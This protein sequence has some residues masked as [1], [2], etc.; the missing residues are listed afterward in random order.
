MPMAASGSASVKSAF[1]RARGAHVEDR[2]DRDAARGRPRASGA[3]S[4][5]RQS[6]DALAAS[7]P[8]SL[9]PWGTAPTDPIGEGGGARRGAVGTASSTAG[10]EDESG[11][12]GT[13]CAASSRGPSDAQQTRPRAPAH[14]AATHRAAGPGARTAPACARRRRSRRRPKGRWI[15]GGGASAPRWFTLVSSYA[16][17]SI[18]AP[19][20]RTSFAGVHGSGDGLS[21]VR[22]ARRRRALV[23]D[24]V[25]STRHSDRPFELA[26]VRGLFLL[27]RGSRSKIRH[28]GSRRSSL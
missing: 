15:A 4:R 16:G 26:D 9:L 21:T 10:F 24:E 20:R 2:T 1:G 17:L 22:D 19:R 27:G 8:T 25:S 11:R 14:R 13:R 5:A 6:R 12:G 18:S 7:P 3:S 23:T 28:A